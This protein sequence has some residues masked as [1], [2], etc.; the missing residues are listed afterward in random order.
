MLNVPPWSDRG[1][2]PNSESSSPAS[3]ISRIER[4]PGLD[5]SSSPRG[6]SSYEGDRLATSVDVANDTP[7][8]CP[9]VCLNMGAVRLVGPPHVVLVCRR[10]QWVTGDAFDLLE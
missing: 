10:W 7:G 9:S 2:T 8:S 4:L 3:V 1:S 6:H 5:R